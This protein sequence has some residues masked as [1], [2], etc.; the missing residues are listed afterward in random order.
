MG[1]FGTTVYYK[2][3]MLL[4]DKFFFAAMIILPVILTLIT[5]YALKYEK[6]NVIPV[7]IADEDRSDYS[8][9]IIERVMKK[10]GLNVMLVSPEEAD[11]LVKNLKVEAAFV[12]KKGFRDAIVRGETS[13]LVDQ[14]VSPASLSGGLIGEI[15]AGEIVRL[16]ENTAAA[17]WV[18]REYKGLDKLDET[19][20]QKLWQEAWNFTDSQWEPKPLMQMEYRERQ[21]K[22]G[23]IMHEAGLK[24]AQAASAGMLIAFLMFFIMF[25]SSWLVEEKHNGTVKRLAAGPDALFVSFT[26]SIA[27]LFTVGA[28]QVV[29]FLVICN[30]L[31]KIDLFNGWTYLLVFAVYLLLVISVSVFASSVL[32]TP[33]QLQAGAPVFSVLTGFAG[34]CFWNFVDVPG[35][36]KTIS[37]FTPQGLALD[38]LNRLLTGDAGATAGYGTVSVPVAAMMAGIVILLT[39]GYNLIKAFVH[40]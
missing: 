33:A 30:K 14:V 8:K 39:A 1:R 22:T 20:R 38:V 3:K 19:G 4:R 32:H 36:L 24:S 40:K 13:G 5:G 9:V 18:V 12:F 2:L 25:N 7:A 35:A 27:A 6:Q 28:L 11:N 23:K 26:G 10:D 17:D 31:F 34:G 37:L 29:V 21:G 16:T 15:I